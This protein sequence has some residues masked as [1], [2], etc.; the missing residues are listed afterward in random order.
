MQSVMHDDAFAL[1]VGNESECTRRARPSR[2]TKATQHASRNV[3]IRSAAESVRQ[4]IALH[5]IGIP[6]FSVGSATGFVR[7]AMEPRLVMPC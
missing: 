4:P 1:Q 6:E 7:I 5:C 3:A 2:Q